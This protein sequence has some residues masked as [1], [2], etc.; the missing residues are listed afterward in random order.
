MQVSAE[1]KTFVDTKTELN[2]RI[3]NIPDC[4]RPVVVL[5]TS[6]SRTL[7]ALEPARRLA[8][9]LGS[10]IVVLAT[11]VI[12]YALQLEEPHIPFDFTIRQFTETAEQFPEN[13]AVVAYRC[14]DRLETLKQVLS[15]DAPVLIGI[16]KRWCPTYDERLARDLG[17]AGYS[18]TIVETE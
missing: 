7:K 14:R 18:V 10:P 1:L 4:S 13:I 16:R 2:K 3:S 11:P 17:R 12:P 8:K 9:T 5:F 15:P 6:A